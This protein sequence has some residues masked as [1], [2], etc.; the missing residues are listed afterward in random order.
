MVVKVLISFVIIAC[1]VLLACETKEGRSP[2]TQISFQIKNFH[3][4]LTE[5]FSTYRG[6]GTIVPSGNP[7]LVKRP[8]LV[9]LKSE[10]IKGGSLTEE[11]RTVRSIEVVDGVGTF[12]T[13]DRA[14]NRDDMFEKPEYEFSIIGYLALGDS[15]YES[16]PDRRP[17]GN[18]LTYSSNG[19]VIAIGDSEFV[20]KTEKKLSRPERMRPVRV[21]AVHITPLEQVTPPQVIRYETE[22][23]EI[24]TVFSGQSCAKPIQ[25]SQ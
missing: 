22:Y 19:T 21:N 17:Y 15:P 10:K 25:T 1:I 3:L 5:H 8:Y 11:R 9:F 6:T 13:Y 20:K 23:E 14:T 4:N 24:A 2:T 16:E 18:V 7:E 12:D